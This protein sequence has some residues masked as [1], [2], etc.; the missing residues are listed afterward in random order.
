M[1]L[2]VLRMN[3]ALNITADNIQ[4]KGEVKENILSPILGDDF[5][6]NGTLKYGNN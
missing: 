2:D 4:I 3:L 6:V 1:K 5:G